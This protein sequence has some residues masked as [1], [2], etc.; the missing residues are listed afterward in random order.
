M[1]ARYYVQGEQIRYFSEYLNFEDKIMKKTA[2]QWWKEN[3]PDPV[4]ATNQHAVDIANYHGV[5]IPKEIEIEH[6]QIGYRIIN[7]TTKEKAL[8]LSEV[9]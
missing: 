5:D 1:E 4:P 6:T 7:I 3:S 8:S 9:W 2:I